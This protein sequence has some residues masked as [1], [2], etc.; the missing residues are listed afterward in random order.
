MTSIVCYGLSRCNTYHED[1]PGVATVAEK[2]IDEVV[3]SGTDLE[4]EGL[5]DKDH[6]DDVEIV[7]SW[8]QAQLELV[9]QTLD[10]NL[11]TLSD[12]VSSEQIDV[13]PQYQ[14]RLRWDEGR[15]SKLIES[16]LMNVPI[17]P[18]FL[19]ETAWGKFAVIDGQQRLRAIHGFFNNEFKLSG[20]EMF[21]DIEGK[22]FKDLPSELRSIL[23]LRP[24]MRCTIILRQ[25]SS[26]LKFE[27]FE[28]LN[29]GSVPLNLQ[30][31]RNSAYRGPLNDLIIELSSSQLFLD[32]LNIKDPLKSD[33]VQKM[34]DC[35]LVLRFFALKDN[36]EDF[37]GS[38]KSTLNNYMETNE[39]L[40]PSK[41]AGLKR[42]FLDTLQM[43]VSVY[44]A[45]SFRRWLVNKD[46]WNNKVMAAMFDAQMIGF[47]KQEIKDPAVVLD[48]SI[49]AFKND[50]Q[51]DASIDKGT[52]AKKSLVYRISKVREILTTAAN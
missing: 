13:K 15:Q 43:V 39:K 48:K 17:P 19:A 23:L 38:M 24:S 45:N 44:G 37:S 26:Q 29:T 7:K 10:Y 28:R 42:D 52:N 41:L 50:K 20:I 6:R 1:T 27:V 11:K 3:T 16:F 33:L 8:A 51:F 5:I 14:R 25:S 22:Y 12:M 4:D 31:I 36:W 47:Y 2:N 46:Q 18:I 30:E 35:E 34:R 49:Q 40:N 21:S 32:A 9:T